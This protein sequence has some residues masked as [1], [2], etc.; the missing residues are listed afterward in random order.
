MLRNINLPDGPFQRVESKWPEATPAAIE[1]AKGWAKS[2]WT[3]NANFRARYFEGSGLESYRWKDVCTG[4]TVPNDVALARAGKSGGVYVVQLNGEDHQDNASRLVAGQQDSIDFWFSE[5]INSPYHRW[6]RFWLGPDSPVLF[7][8]Q[9]LVEADPDK[10]YEDRCVILQHLDVLPFQLTNLFF[11]GLRYGYECGPKVKTFC[12]LL[13]VGVHPKIAYILSIVYSFQKGYDGPRFSFV[14]RLPSY[15]EDPNGNYRDNH[16]IEL[17]TAWARAHKDD[18]YV[19]AN[20]GQHITIDYPSWTFDGVMK[21]TWRGGCFPYAEGGHT[22]RGDFPPQKPHSNGFGELAFTSA[23]FKQFNNSDAC[24]Y[25]LF[26]LHQYAGPGIYFNQLISVAE[27][28][29]EAYDGKKKLTDAKTFITHLS[30]TAG[31]IE[32]KEVY[33]GN[34]V[35]EL[36]LADFDDEDREPDDDYYDDDYDEGN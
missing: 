10:V 35:G 12:N 25:V 2:D 18:G 5:D 14:P 6:L 24:A 9:F 7:M 36:T 30:E 17:L 19:H 32:A 11:I 8:Q 13:D 1:K 20:G 34:Y 3:S 21:Q 16:G 29:Q 15:I 27:F 4:G 31:K 28:L 23:K 33:F 26:S 22:Y